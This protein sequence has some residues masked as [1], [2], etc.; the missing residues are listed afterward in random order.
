[1]QRLS[2][3]IFSH[4][5][6]RH[7][8]VWEPEQFDSWK[9]VSF[10]DRQKQNCMDN[11]KHVWM[12]WNVWSSILQLTGTIGS[13]IVNFEGELRTSIL[14]TFFIFSGSSLSYQR[15]LYRANSSPDYR[16][17]LEYLHDCYVH[18]HLHIANLPIN[19]LHFLLCL[20]SFYIEDVTSVFSNKSDSS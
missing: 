9:Q 8:V 3:Q 10:Q 11:S 13:K 5:H 2:D 18:F 17:I 15:V 16:R 14:K 20:L 7:H 12:R 19:M 1:M 4:G 6:F